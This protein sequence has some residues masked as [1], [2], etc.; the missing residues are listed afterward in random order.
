MAMATMRAMAIATVHASYANCAYECMVFFF[1]LNS[2][3]PRLGF[4]HVAHG[5]TGVLGAEFCLNSNTILGHCATALG[6]LQETIL[7]QIMAKYRDH[8]NL[9][10]TILFN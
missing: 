2:H 6:L 4:E 9:H 8:V 5:I 3:L 1:A 10:S 7:G